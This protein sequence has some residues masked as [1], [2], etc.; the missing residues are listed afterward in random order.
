M[1][2]AR[3]HDF[4]PHTAGRPRPRRRA[5]LAG[6]VGNFV[7]WYEFGVYGYFATVI[8]ARFFTPEGGSETEGLVRTYA[9]FALA[10]FFRPVGA[11]L[12]GR[13]GDRIGRRPVL[14]LVIALMTGATTLIGVLPT[15]ATIGA[16]APW[17]LTFLRWSK[18]CPRAGSS[19][20][21]SRS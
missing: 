10:F 21:R 17:L 9:S 2:D 1:S 13:L 5:L 8:A 11:A 4:V 19:G 15:Y 16:L 20:A 18:G 12:F 14:I 6:S 3:V 7:E